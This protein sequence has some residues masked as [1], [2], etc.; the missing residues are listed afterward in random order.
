M[1]SSYYN[2]YPK[3]SLADICSS[4][5]N[6]PGSVGID[7]SCGLRLSLQVTVY[8]VVIGLSRS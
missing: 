1:S 5:I 3:K 4:F 6:P 8:P 7:N 2:L